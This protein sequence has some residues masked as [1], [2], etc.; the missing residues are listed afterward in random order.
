MHIRLVELLSRRVMAGFVRPFT[1][2]TTW[3]L[4]KNVDARDKRGTE[5]IL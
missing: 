5:Q 4:S 3:Q 2:F 1:I